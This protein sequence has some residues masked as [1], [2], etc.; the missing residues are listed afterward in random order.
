MGWSSWR[1]GDPDFEI[2]YNRCELPVPLTIDQNAWL[3]YA[4]IVNTTQTGASVRLNQRGE[5]NAFRRSRYLA[6]TTPISRRISAG[7]E[8]PR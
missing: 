5:I 3:N 6:R 7:D 8:T 4:V 2:R 1:P